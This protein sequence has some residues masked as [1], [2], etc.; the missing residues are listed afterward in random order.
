VVGVG[1]GLLARLLPEL[2]LDPLLVAPVAIVVVAAL[3]ISRVWTIAAALSAAALLPYTLILAALP[4]TP[5]PR[6]VVVAVAAALALVTLSP[7][8]NKERRRARIS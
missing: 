6:G 4:D 2:F 5:W 1:V 8:W 7:A 3:R